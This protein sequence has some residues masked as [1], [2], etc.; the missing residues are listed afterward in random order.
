MPYFSFIKDIKGDFDYTLN[1]HG[2][3]NNTIRDGQITIRNG[4]VDILQLDNRI[5]NINAYA[6][7]NNNRLIIN[8]FDAELPKP[9]G[10]EDLIDGIALTVKDVF[11]YNDANTG[12]IGVV[13]SINLESFFNPDLSL[14]IVGRNNYLSSSYG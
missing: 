2:N 5:S 10:S 11:D 3:Y 4:Y 14:N 1:I 7:I 6:V 13:G 9:V 12:S 8:N